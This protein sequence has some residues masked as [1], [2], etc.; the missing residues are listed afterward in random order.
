MEDGAG[1][2]VARPADNVGLD[3]SLIFLFLLSSVFALYPFLGVLDLG[4]NITYVLVYLGGEHKT[5]VV[6]CSALFC[7]GF[8]FAFSASL[9]SLGLQAEAQSI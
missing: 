5:A 3:M 7:I 2:G 8:W 1:G 9:Y 6:P 4:V